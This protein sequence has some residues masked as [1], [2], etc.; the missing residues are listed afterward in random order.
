MRRWLTPDLF[1]FGDSREEGHPNWN[2]VRAAA[3][4]NR[5]LLTK[6]Q[7]LLATDWIALLKDEK[8]FIMAIKTNFC[9]SQLRDFLRMQRNVSCKCV[10]CAT[11]LVLLLGCCWDEGLQEFLDSSRLHVCPL[12]L[13]AM[14]KTQ[15]DKMRQTGFVDE[16]AINPKE[17]PVR[18]LVSCE[19]DRELKSVIARYAGELVESQKHAQTLREWWERRSVFA[20]SGSSSMN[21]QEAREKAG[22]STFGLNKKVAVELITYE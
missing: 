14:S 13:W 2:I 1:V 7:C 17:D 12:N 9:D 6:P 16:R 15:M 8:E 20:L 4:M 19:D 3:A 22:L 21:K 5:I 11:N 10:I 18:G